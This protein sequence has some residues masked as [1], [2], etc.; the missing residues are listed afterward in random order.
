MDESPVGVQ[1]D[2]MDK[3]QLIW[4]LKALTQFM[5]TT[6]LELIKASM[7]RLKMKSRLVDVRACSQH[8]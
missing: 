5:L 3:E 4:A 2:T 8:M 6:M 1:N 7:I